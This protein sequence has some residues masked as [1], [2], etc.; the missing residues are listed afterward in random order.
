MTK[1]KQMSP[2]T[3]EYL[4]IHTEVDKFMKKHKMTEISMDF[5]WCFAEV[6]IKKIQKVLDKH[7]EDMK[8]LHL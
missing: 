5:W 6:L 2:I 3:K 8:N 1:T 7:F 4:H